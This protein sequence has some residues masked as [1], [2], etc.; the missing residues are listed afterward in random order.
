MRRQRYRLRVTIVGEYVVDL[1][2]FEKDAYGKNP[3]AKSIARMEERALSFSDFVHMLDRYKLQICPV[4]RK[5]R[6]RA[7]RG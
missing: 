7:A 3:T 4:A 5:T 6:K 1:T 2:D